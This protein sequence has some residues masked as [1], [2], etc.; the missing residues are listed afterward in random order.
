MDL[1]DFFRRKEKAAQREMP[2]AAARYVVVD[3]ELTG[4]DERKDSIVS[5]GAIRMEGGRI[6]MGETFYCLVRPETEM[7]RESIIVHGITPSEAC[8]G[9][10]IEDALS[11]LSRFCGDD[12]VTGHFISIDLAFI[13]REMKRLFRKRLKNAAVDTFA[14]YDWLRMRGKVDHPRYYRL[15]EIAKAMDIPVE[16]SHNALVDA[17]ITAQLFQRLLPGLMEAGVTDLGGILSIGHP[18][19]GGEGKSV[20]GEICNF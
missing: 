19:K 4:L 3:T 20:Y 2:L 15:Y 9:H 14:L 13:N 7:R 5:I 18:S 11:G 6:C 12:I 16:G 10:S 1:L 8:D 17:F